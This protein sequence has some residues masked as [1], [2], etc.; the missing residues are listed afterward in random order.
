MAI[1]RDANMIAIK[2]EVLTKARNGKWST[3]IIRVK[4]ISEYQKNV[5][6]NENGCH[7]Y[8]GTLNK[9]G[10]AEPRIDGK[11][12]RLH[13]AA[14]AHT[15]G[16]LPRPDHLIVC[17]SCGNRACINPRHLYLGTTKDNARDMVLHGNAGKLKGEMVGNSKLKKRDILSIRSSDLMGIDLA[18]QYK[19]TPQTISDVRSRK[20]WVHV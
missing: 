10:Y 3:R 5:T 16:P 7:V 9:Q 20:T 4:S 15:Y 12:M 18:K 11:L 2:R 6:I 8:N 17:H 14:Y 1:R 19:V 13:R